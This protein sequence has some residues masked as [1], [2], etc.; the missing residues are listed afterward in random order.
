MPYFTD[1]RTVAVPVTDQDRAVAFYTKTL[2]FELLL[3]A[4]LPQIGGRWIVVAPPG[5]G[6][7]LA[8]TQAVTCGVDSGVRLVTPDAAAA[9]AH[10]TQ[11]GVD[12]DDLL[13]WPG[14]PPMFSFR[15]Q[16]ANIVYAVQE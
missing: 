1:I 13:E 8:L 15:D 14:V 9:H 10:L 3:D 4:P 16:D 12:T 11:Q 2:G 5:A 6:T 7:D